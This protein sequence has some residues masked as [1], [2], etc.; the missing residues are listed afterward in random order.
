[1][2]VDY[3]RMN[4]ACLTTNVSKEV[5]ESMS[6]TFIGHVLISFYFLFFYHHFILPVGKLSAAAT[7]APSVF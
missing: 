6:M 4:A 7:R 2:V 3:Y 1:M 5:L